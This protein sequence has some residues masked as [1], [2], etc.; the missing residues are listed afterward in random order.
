MP[1]AGNGVSVDRGA[2]KAH[3]F[4]EDKLLNKPRNWARLILACA[5]L[6]PSAFAQDVERP[7]ELEFHYGNMGGAQSSSGTGSMPAPGSA[8]VTLT[9]MP[10]RRV[11]SWYF[12]DGAALLNQVQAQRSA[13]APTISPLDK[14]LNS[15]VVERKPAAS[16]GVRL[17]RAITGRFA[18]EFTLDYSLGKMAITQEGIATIDDARSSFASTWNALG[19]PNIRVSSVPT[20]KNSV[21]S[22]IFTTGSL[23]IHLKTRGQ[24]IPYASAGAGAVTRL[25]GVPEVT[26]AGSYNFPFGGSTISES[27]SVHV[28]YGTSGTVR[29]GVLGGGLKYHASPRWGI[30]GDVRVYISEN[31][32]ATLLDATPKLTPNAPNGG[33]LASTT[34]PSLQLSADQSFRQSTLNS[35]EVVRF[36]TFKAGG[37]QNR[38]AAHGGIFWRF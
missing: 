5:A 28:K 22:E 23:L 14:A 36:P 6:V 13:T 26:L 9:N 3:H 4:K 27:D 25:G 32:T 33:A 16:F 31:D 12:G 37:Y 15:S 38:I 17:N 19:I 34:S 24:W 29:V 11:S 1:R 10:S 7:W 2:E 20:I 8:F 18:A 35:L 21:G 30:R